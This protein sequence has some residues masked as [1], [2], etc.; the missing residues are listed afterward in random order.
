MPRKR[1]RKPDL[2]GIFNIEFQGKIVSYTLKRSSQ[3]RYIRMEI[4]PDQGLV[5][6]IPRGVSAHQVNDF[7]RNR[8][9]WVTTH[10]R[11][12]LNHLEPNGNK[13]ISNGDV[14]DYLGSGLKI[15]TLNDPDKPAIVRIREDCL[16]VNLNHTG[17]EL[18][19]ALEDWYRFQAGVLIKTKLDWM[20]LRMDLKYTTV[21][22]RGQRTRWGSCSQNGTLSFNWKLLKMPEPVIEYV[23]IH[24]LAHLKEMNHSRK[25]WSLVAKFCP[26]YK[27][28]RKW[29][30]EHNEMLA[31]WS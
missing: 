31:D 2:I 5:V 20:S 17:T 8:E 10:L 7:I 18:A 21:A 29:L 11:R 6:V 15:K 14:V 25:F 4:R 16:E 27:I 22:L 13:P 1:F 19:A 3:A 28:H 9:K 23:V 24:E 26:E 30:R 12:H